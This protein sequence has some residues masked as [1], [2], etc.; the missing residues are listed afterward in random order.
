M[1]NQEVIWNILSLLEIMEE[2]L[3]YIKERIIELNIEA[4]PTVLSDTIAAFSSIEQAIAPMLSE[5]EENKIQ[6]KAEKLKDGFNIIVKEYEKKNGQKY[7]EIIQLSIEPAFKEW[8]EEI[9]LRIRP[10]VES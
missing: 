10:Y 1:P 9:E 7:S 6:E 3:D 8:K 4:T 2:G 5:L